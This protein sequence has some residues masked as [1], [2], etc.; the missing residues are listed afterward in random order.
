MRKLYTILI[1][2]TFVIGGLWA[3]NIDEPAFVPVIPEV[4]AQG[5]SFT[6]VANG[7]NSLFYNPA[8]FAS[9]DS[10]LTILSTTCWAYMNP[11]SI[12]DVIDAMQTND[13]A[14]IAETVG[15]QITSGG[16][17]VGTSAGLGLITGGL[18]VG[19][20]LI[21]DSNVYGGDN[22]LDVSADFHA[23][24]GLVAGYALNLNLLGLNWKIGADLRPMYRIHVPVPNDRALGL[25][26]G[27]LNGNTDDAFAELNS[28][29]ALA[30]IGVGIDIG[31]MVE[32]GPVIAALSIRDAF[33]TSFNYNSVLFEEFMESFSGGTEPT[34][35]EV[36]DDYVIPMDVSAGVAFH[37]DLGALSWLIDPTIHADIQDIV[38]VIANG[39][40]PWTLI[41]IG[42]EAKILR[43]LK[44]RAGFNQGYITMGVGAHLL[45]FDI[46]AAVFTRE[47]GKY[48]KDQPNSGATIEV[49]FRL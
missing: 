47:L 38:G 2:F 37:P 9:E 36:S 42:A 21:I 39:R 34:G 6:A 5:G 11:A 8:G 12:G 48:I 18:G 35:E 16:I 32:L 4:M 19:A 44:A 29:A 13:Q 33:G 1:I 25:I 28:Q 30:G 40:S 10:D 17:G 23:T 15:G 24:L 45:F 3:E 26:T 31:T 22:I 20:A 7:F 46:N 43:V 27:L 41:H 14:I 49:A